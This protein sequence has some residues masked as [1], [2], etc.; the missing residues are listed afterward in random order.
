MRMIV[1]A[2]SAVVTHF[3]QASDEKIA[4]TDKA[5][6]QVGGKKRKDG[7]GRAPSFQRS[8]SEQSVTDYC[9]EVQG[10]HGGWGIS[11]TL[12]GVTALAEA[13]IT[14]TNSRTFLSIGIS[15]FWNWTASTSREDGSIL[16]SR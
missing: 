3:N 10:Q 7:S 6:L 1:A 9:C 11:R 8:S 5:S 13:T 4:C 12:F 2:N 14:A 15:S 16:A